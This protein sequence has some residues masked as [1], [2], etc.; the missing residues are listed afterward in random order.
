MLWPLLF[1][2]LTACQ[3]LKEDTDS[4]SQALLFQK[5]KSLKERAY[6][7]EAL[8]QFRKFKTRYLYSPLA[9]QAELSVADIY[10][11]KEAWPEAVKAYQIFLEKHPHHK[12]NDR[13]VF[14][15]A[16]SYFHQLP[17]TAD[18][19]L[20][21]TQKALFYFKK[22]LKNFPDS[23]FRSQAFTHL[24]K[25]LYLKAKKEWQT[26]QFH[27]KQNQPLRSLPYLRHLIKTYPPL[28]NHKDFKTPLPSKVRLQKMLKQFS[29]QVK[30]TG[31]TKLKNP[32]EFIFHGRV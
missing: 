28:E 7:T 21:L 6:Y 17:N 5:A 9:T 26:V 30:K 25:V 10:F 27:L 16:L 2:F 3:S 4:P 22:H 18:R 24:N 12:K 23:S 15:L 14:H 13:V 11:L 29:P 1:L 8:I 19:D 32:R 31:P 20:S